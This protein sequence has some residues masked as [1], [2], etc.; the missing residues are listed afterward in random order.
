MLR[1][2]TCSAVVLLVLAGTARAQERE[3]PSPYFECPYINY[4]DSDCPQLKKEQPLVPQPAEDEQEPR[5]AGDEEEMRHDWLQEMPEHLLPLFPKES[6]APDTP[7]LYRL[8]LIRPTLKTARR[9]VRWH[10]RRMSRIREAQ[11]LIEVAGREVLA[12]RAARE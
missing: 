2:W 9:L 1:Y 12:E 4:F 8:L 11:G 5:S 10:A 3:Q 7:D 6:L